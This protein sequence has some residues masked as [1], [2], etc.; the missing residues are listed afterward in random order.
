MNGGLFEGCKR[1]RSLKGVGMQS[2]ELIRIQRIG[3][4]LR[5]TK[6]NGLLKVLERKYTVTVVNEDLSFTS[7]SVSYKSRP[8]QIRF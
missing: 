3:G 6:G 4:C 7:P 5:D 2:M 1:E 8:E